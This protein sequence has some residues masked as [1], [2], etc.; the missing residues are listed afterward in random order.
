MQLKLVQ[1]LSDCRHLHSESSK[2]YE[3]I[4]A[5][6]IRFRHFFRIQF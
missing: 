3:H 1:S 2:L 4:P 5:E 6:M